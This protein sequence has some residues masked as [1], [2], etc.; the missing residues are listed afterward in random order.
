MSRQLDDLERNRR[1]QLRE[2]FAPLFAEAGAEL[3]ASAAAYGCP[4]WVRQSGWQV[5]FTW[6]DDSQYLEYEASWGLAG[7]QIHRRLWADGRS[8]ELDA[9]NEF[10]VPPIEPDVAAAIAQRQL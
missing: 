4:G 1:A 2:H 8:D 6:S 10:A 5:S 3:P 9:M 7:D